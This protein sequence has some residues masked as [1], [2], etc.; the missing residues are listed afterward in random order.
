[1]V[2]QNAS[3]FFRLPVDFVEGKLQRRLPATAGTPD[4]SLLGSGFTTKM[5]LQAAVYPM[6]TIA[7][8]RLFVPASVQNPLYDSAFQSSYHHTFWR[9]FIPAAA[10]PHAIAP[11]VPLVC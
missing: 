6:L 9:R 7:A 8:G 10:A 3:L 11:P 1:M 5:P 4:D 2:A